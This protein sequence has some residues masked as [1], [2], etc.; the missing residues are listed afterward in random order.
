[1]RPMLRTRN[2]N[3]PSLDNLRP[4]SLQFNYQQSITALDQIFINASYNGM[5]FMFHASKAFKHFVRTEQVN[6]PSVNLDLTTKTSRLD[7]MT[8]YSACTNRGFGMSSL[9]F[10]VFWVEC[11]KYTFALNPPK[12]Q[13]NVG[14]R[15]S[16]STKIVIVK[17]VNHSVAERNE[18][19]LS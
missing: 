19:I 11:W 4:L 14:R 2:T 18:T 5:R 9:L 12:K 15:H 3:I 7:W 1:M 10:T 6:S 17:S 16:T 8:S 13:K